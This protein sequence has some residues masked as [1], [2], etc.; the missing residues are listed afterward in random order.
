MAEA[1]YDTSRI[2][3]TDPS[4]EKRQALA[5]H[6]G[7]EAAAGN[8]DACGDADVV[9]LAVKPQT[10]REVTVGLADTLAARR[11]LV[12]SIAAGVRETDLNRWLGYGGPIVRCMPN[13]PALLREGVTALYA[14]AYTSAPQREQAQAILETAGAVLWLEDE[15]LMDTVTAVSGSGPAYFFL[16][17]EALQSAGERHGLAREQAQLLATRTALGAARMAAGA[18]AEG[19]GELRDRVTS[20]GGT[21]AEALAVFEQLGLPALVNQAVEAAVARARELGDELGAS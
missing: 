19:P 8:N 3:V 9:V 12:V 15:A 17:M 10:L 16:F 4:A 11:P 5:D 6:F 7:I 2:R 18:D 20:K 1:G 13:T 21:T 14:N